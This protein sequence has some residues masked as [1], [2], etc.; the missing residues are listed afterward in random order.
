MGII[1]MCPV[2]EAEHK[3]LHGLIS[4]VRVCV[5]SLYIFLFVSTATLIFFVVFAE[6]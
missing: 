1:C 4:M 6:V 5:Y 3:F 2:I